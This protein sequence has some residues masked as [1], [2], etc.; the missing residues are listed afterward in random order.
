MAL[1]FTAARKFNESC[2]NDDSCY[3]FGSS[4]ICVNNDKNNEF[5]KVCDC[6]PSVSYKDEEALACIVVRGE[7][8]FFVL[9]CKFSP[10]LFKIPIYR[11]YIY[12]KLT[13]SS[14]IL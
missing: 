3:T 5:L 13:K 8:I 2:V 11:T 10:V 12:L 9:I 7:F 1:K 4:S 14:F 6:D